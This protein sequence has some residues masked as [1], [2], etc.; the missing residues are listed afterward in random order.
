MQ[1][2]GLIETIEA[3]RVELAEAVARGKNQ[4]VQFPVGPIELE[5]QVGVTRE[6]DGSAG[7][8]FWVLELEAKGRLSNEVIQKVTVKL[9]APVD[10]SGRPIKVSLSRGEK[11]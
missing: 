7:V 3:L 8:K 11:P 9:E 6:A 1:K 2:I 4:E 5:F 10:R